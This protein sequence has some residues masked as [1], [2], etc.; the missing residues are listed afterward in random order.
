MC[1]KTMQNAVTSLMV[2]LR[3]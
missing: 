2:N 1:Y 3:N